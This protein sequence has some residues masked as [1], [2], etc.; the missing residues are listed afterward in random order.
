MGLESLFVSFIRPEYR[1]KDSMRSYDG[2]SRGRR[3]LLPFLPEGLIE[4]DQDASLNANHFEF[5]VATESTQFRIDL[6]FL[7]PVSAQ[8]TVD[9]NQSIKV[10]TRIDQWIQIEC[11]CNNDNTWNSRPLSGLEPEE[12]WTVR[13]ASAS[14]EAAAR[15]HAVPELELSWRPVRFLVQPIARVLVP[16]QFDLLTWAEWRLLPLSERPL[17]YFQHPDWMIRLEPDHSLSKISGSRTSVGLT[18]GPGK[19]TARGGC[20]PQAFPDRRA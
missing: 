20:H 1:R 19:I 4:E 11:H 18:G 12:N 6:D 10:A 14:I 8:R 9:P 15:L 13:I 17:D 3:V 16:L 2:Q 7:N 5:W